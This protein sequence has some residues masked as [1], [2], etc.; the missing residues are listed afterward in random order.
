MTNFNENHK[1]MSY[2]GLI[3]NNNSTFKNSFTHIQPVYYVMALE[4]HYCNHIHFVKHKLQSSDPQERV[5]DPL[6]A[7]VP[8]FRDHLWEL[9]ECAYI[10]VNL[11]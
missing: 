10:K 6:N 4:G 9:C 1:N 2:G 3:R 5:R 8:C 7:Q 11:I